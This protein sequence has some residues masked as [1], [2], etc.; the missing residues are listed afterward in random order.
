MLPST[1]GVLA[2]LGFLF[3][4]LPGLTVNDS[5]V[6][7]VSRSVYAVEGHVPI[8]LVL[9]GLAAVAPLLP[10]GSRFVLPTALL[11]VAGV[12]AAVT[13]FTS[14]TSGYGSTYGRGVGLVLLM[15][16]AFLE[17]VAA[18]YHWLTDARSSKP[19]TPA[20]DRF[21]SSSGRGSATPSTAVPGSFL[22]VTGPGAPTFAPP[23]TSGGPY[24]DRAGPGQLGGYPQGGF[25]PGPA[26]SSTSPPPDATDYGGYHP[27]TY[28]P[29][30]S[31]ASPFG[32]A[33]PPA[34]DMS[35]QLFRTGADPA[36]S[37]P[38]PYGE[39]PP[40]PS[41]AAAQN[42]GEDR[43]GNQSGPEEEPP[44]DI[45]QQVRF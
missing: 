35:G 11:S 13:A 8:L 3:G 34:A 45:T 6:G 38:S 40:A 25:I 15:I 7:T 2:L 9:V 4:F 17:A 5:D 26:G 21:T 29:P 18:I 31:P 23:P 39:R 42:R 28:R 33:A 44:P 19:A 27:G 41:P 36:A 10:G 22:P 14:V 43:T 16:V 37:A 32:S 1:I 20:G 30:G 24:P 12:L